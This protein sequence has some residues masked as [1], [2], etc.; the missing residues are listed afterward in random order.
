MYKNI[1]VPVLLDKE[2]DTAA[3]YEVAQAISED[4]AKFHVIHVMETIPSYATTQIPQE[5]LDHTRQEAAEEMNA[6]AKALP[7]AETHLVSGHAGR[8]ILDYADK[9]G[10]DCIVLASHRPGMEDFFLGSTAARV[11]RHAK[12]SV[13]VIR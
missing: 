13:H 12:C 9:H 5:I 7:G 8:A 3:S 11:V 4:G 1:L 2:H 6:S 10:C